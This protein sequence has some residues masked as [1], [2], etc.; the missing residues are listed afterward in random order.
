MDASQTNAFHQAV[1]QMRKTYLAELPEKL[2]RLENLLLEIEGS[3]AKRD[4]FDELY[5]IVHSMKGSGGTF[6]L[7]ILTTICHQF[8]DLLS[9]TDGGANFSKELIGPCL[10]YVD[11]LR[12]AAEQCQSGHETF[13]QVEEQ[14]GVL[15][16]QLAPK[17]FT[18][19]LIDNSKLSTKLYV[20]LL[21][22]L[23]VRIL[24]M[25]DGPNALMRALTEPFDLII[26]NYEI[27]VLN[28][29]ALIGAVKLSDTG[30]RNA[31]T[32]LITSNKQLAATR[33]RS[34]DPD[35]SIIKDAKLAQNL[36]EVVKRAL[37]IHSG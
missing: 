2:D 12:M 27:P 4:A 11:L 20:Q 35:Y 6:G 29:T 22:D 24:A 7:H 32:I 23:P 15:R 36:V 3:G 26:S 17:Q 30:S 25:D 33:N 1:S 8:E 9:N 16:K 10:D 19:L 18:I 21:S 14:L 34:T 5:R 37:A 31:K 13:P 28:G